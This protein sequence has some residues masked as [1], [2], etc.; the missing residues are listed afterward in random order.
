MKQIINP[1]MGLL[2]VGV[3]QPASAREVYAFQNTVFRSG[4]KLPPVDDFEG[5]LHAQLQSGHLLQVRSGPEALYSLTLHGNHYLPL[6]VRKL[7]DKLRMYL[8]RDAH[9][10]RVASSPGNTDEGL[11]GA[12]PA[13]DT[14]SGLK[15]TAANKFGRPGQIYWPRIQWQFEEET[16]LT[17]SPGDSFP[18]LLSFETETQAAEAAGTST[19]EF[20]LDYA[21]L[22]LCLGVSTKIISQIA[23]NPDRHYRHFVLPKKGGGERPIESP[24]VFLRVIQWFLADFVFH[25]LTFHNSVHSFVLGR[26]IVTNA[27]YHVRRAFVA[28]VDIKGFFSNITE[29]MV[30]ECLKRNG[31]KPVECGLLAKL[32]TNENRLPQGAPS[33][34]ILSNAILYEFDRQMERNCSDRLLQYSRY[35]DDITI[36]GE[37]RAEV[38]RGIRR[39]QTLLREQYNL[40]LHEDKTRIASKSGQQ[41]VT[42]VVVNQSVVPPRVFRRRI[43]AM[44]HQASLSPHKYVTQITELR[45]YVGFLK[46]FPKL[47]EAQDIIGYE[48]ILTDLQSIKRE[49]PRVRARSTAGQSPAG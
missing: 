22:G 42:G 29:D 9:R 34:P 25:D 28:N 49:T 7:R 47:R 40:E 26:S 19:T 14:S 48:K 8:L 11:A 2:A 4:G 24:R 18:A 16:G 27:E 23:H 17:R 36:S 15:R 37:D 3:L 31:F 13:P 30:G 45:G 1:H 43:R 12:S 6:R 41:R 39:C 46:S 44:F 20:V 38:Q 5:F 32:C 21:G 10:R 35:A 33:S